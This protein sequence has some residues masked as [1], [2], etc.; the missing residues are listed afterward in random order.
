MEMAEGSL[1]D[2][3]EVKC[4]CAQSWRSRAV[5]VE[6]QIDCAATPCEGGKGVVEEQSEEE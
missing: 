5:V 1:R 6:T 4:R 2:G 3:V